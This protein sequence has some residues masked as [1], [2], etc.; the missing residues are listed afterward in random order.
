MECFNCELVFNEEDEDRFWVC[1]DGCDNGIALHAVYLMNF[2]VR[3]AHKIALKTVCAI[4][5]V[6]IDW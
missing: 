4:E 5:Q 6:I 3:N 2:I 1:C